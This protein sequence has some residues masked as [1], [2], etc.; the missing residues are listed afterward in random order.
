VYTVKSL[1]AVAMASLAL[2]SGLTA[3]VADG[4]ARATLLQARAATK[5]QAFQEAVTMPS[6]GLVL[7]NTNELRSHSFEGHHLSL[8][9]GATGGGTAEGGGPAILYAPSEGDD[10]AYRASIS[11]ASG[12]TVDYFDGVVG[13]PSLATMLQYDAVYTWTN[14]AYADPTTFGNNLAAYN[15]MGGT[16]VLGVF[17][18]FTSGNSMAGT[19]MTSGYCPVVSPSG[20]NHFTTSSYNGG[21]SSCIYSGVAALTCDFRDILDTQGTGIED[22]LY[23]DGEIVHAYRAGTSG[24]QGDVV[25]SNGS[26]AFQLGAPSQWGTAVGNA[27]SCGIDVSSAW[28]DQGSALGGVAGDPTLVG[29]GSL[30]GDT[31]NILVLSNAAGSALSSIFASTTSSP[32]AF[33]G[34]TLLP[35]PSIVSL[36]LNTNASGGWMLTFRPPVGLTG[37]LWAQAAIQDGAAPFGV[38]LSNGIKGDIP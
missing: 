4:G 2:G 32:T 16:V 28:S 14:F 7:T 6:T 13:T 17:C 9:S 21:G 18:S 31:T 37:E 36:N 20:G 1:F 24:S 15:D 22:G 30:R 27:A 19:I 29:L 5:S 12:A 25:Y 33:Y 11:A 3:Q 8:A 23:A 35:G 26:G 34:G 10:A 38:A